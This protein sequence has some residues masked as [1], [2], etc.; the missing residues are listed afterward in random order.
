MVKGNDLI[1]AR[2][3]GSM[4]DMNSIEVTDKNNLTYRI[5]A[6]EILG[7]LKKLNFEQKKARKHYYLTIS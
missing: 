7:I 3:L 4:Y 1:G 6:G 5:T 2:T